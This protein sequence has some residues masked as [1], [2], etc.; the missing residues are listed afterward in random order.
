MDVSPL[1]NPCAA[2]TP[3]PFS[4]AAASPTAATPVAFR[5][6]PQGAADLPAAL[7][8]QLV[9]DGQRSAVP[10]PAAAAPMVFSAAGTTRAARTGRKHRQAGRKHPSDPPAV[11]LQPPEGYEASMQR[12]A[13]DLLAQRRAAA[14][15]RAEVLHQEGNALYKARQ[16]DAAAAQ[17]MQGVAAL[18]G[19]DG[20]D[21]RR[22]QLL[23]NCAACR[24]MLRQPEQAVALSLQALQVLGI[25]GGE[26]VE[27]VWLF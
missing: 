27:M 24:I 23:T 12:A 19:L 9:L 5:A 16:Y 10:T 6:P 1:G 15:Q 21:A 26:H 17:F 7:E 20:V 4:F 13:D 18:E 25:Y 11:A 22:L 14:A 3:P 8:E 2:P